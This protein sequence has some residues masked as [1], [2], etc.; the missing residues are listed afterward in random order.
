[1][2]FIVFGQTAQPVQPS[3]RAVRDLAFGQHLKQVFWG[4]F[5]FLRCA[6]MPIKTGILPRSSRSFEQEM[7]YVGEKSWRRRRDFAGVSINTRSKT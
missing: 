4:A 7:Y 5:V 1:M 3:R 6:Y 2:P